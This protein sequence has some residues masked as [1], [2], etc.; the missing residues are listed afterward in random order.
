QCRRAAWKS[1]LFPSPTNREEARRMYEYVESLSKSRTGSIVILKQQADENGN[2]VQNQAFIDEIYRDFE[3]EAASI[4]DR[5]RLVVYRPEIN[6]TRE[7][8]EIEHPAVLVAITD[9][10]EAVKEMIVSLKASLPK[11]VPIIAPDTWTSDAI[12]T[13]WKDLYHLPVCAFSTRRAP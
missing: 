10:S 12:L 4:R 8:Q 1:L 3:N 6:L 9:E 7:L 2:G 5:L 13:H 11:D